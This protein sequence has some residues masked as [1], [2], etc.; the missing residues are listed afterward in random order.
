MNNSPSNF[1][2]PIARFGVPTAASFSYDTIVF[3]CKVC[4]ELTAIAVGKSS[5]FSAPAIF[6]VPWKPYSSIKSSGSVAPAIAPNT[7][8]R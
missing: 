8:A 4:L 6:N 3:S 5:P 7:L 1:V 2:L